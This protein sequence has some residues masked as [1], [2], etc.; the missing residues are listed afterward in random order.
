MTPLALSDIGT[1]LRV[2]VYV[3]AFFVML[4]LSLPGVPCTVSLPAVMVANG[5]MPAGVKSRFTFS[6]PTTTLP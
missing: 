6:L 3:V 2:I 1:L 5:A 4:M